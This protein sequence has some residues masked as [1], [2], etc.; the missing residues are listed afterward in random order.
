[1]TNTK[2]AMALFAAILAMAAIH[3][4]ANANPVWQS[5]GGAC[6]P[7][8]SSIQ[9]DGYDLADTGG[10]VT[11]TTGTTSNQYFV[12]AVQNGIDG[13]YV[14]VNLY[15]ADVGA[16][17]SVEA[18]LYRKARSGGTYSSVCSI[19]STANSSWHL[20]SST[21]C[22]TLDTSTYI[23]WVFVRME[24]TAAQATKFYAVELD[25]VVE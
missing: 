17:D 3:S 19:T 8:N 20:D 24:R 7:Y 14:Q 5:P 16:N 13:S 18:I 4:P 11:F 21:P 1:M 25:E 6:V 12:C 2:L 10:R 23:Y 15:S 9:A 22:G